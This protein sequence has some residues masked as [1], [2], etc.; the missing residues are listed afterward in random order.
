[1]QVEFRRLLTSERYSVSALQASKEAKGLERAQ[2][3]LLKRL[4]ELGK[5][6]DLS[7]IIEVEKIVVDTE[8][9]YYANS[10]AMNSSLKAALQELSVIEEHIGKVGDAARYRALDDDHRLPRNRKGGLPN[11]EARQALRSHYTRLNNMDK[12]RLGDVEKQ[13]IDARKS[14]IFQAEKLYKDR[15]AKVLGLDGQQSCKRGV[16]R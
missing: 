15:Q 11:D 7:M 14:N 9:A 10:K 13:I 1:M 5:S 16:G 6:G 8:R 2:K 4:R 12:A 3:N